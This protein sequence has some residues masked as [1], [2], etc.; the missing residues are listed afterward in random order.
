VLTLSYQWEGFTDYYKEATT[1]GGVLSK[2]GLDF[3][4]QILQVNVGEGSW[5]NS[6]AMALEHD[7]FGSYHDDKRAKVE[8]SQLIEIKNRDDHSDDILKEYHGSSLRDCELV[9][10]DP[11]VWDILR[12]PQTPDRKMASN[13]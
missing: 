8:V 11:Y 13:P 6:V 3:T 1:L 12:L 10:S 2:P 7:E 5:E 9:K 4:L